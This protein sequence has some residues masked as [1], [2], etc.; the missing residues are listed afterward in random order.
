MVLVV[1]KRIEGDKEE[2]FRPTPKDNLPVP[3]AVKK[4]EALI[5]VVFKFHK[6]ELLTLS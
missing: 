3:Y 5:C 4:E 6:K 2:G 1:S